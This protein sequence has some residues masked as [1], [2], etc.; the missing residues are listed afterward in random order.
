MYTADAFYIP[1]HA[2]IHLFIV[3]N[4]THC[5]PMNYLFSQK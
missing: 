5:I 1:V 2:V 3:V 4:A